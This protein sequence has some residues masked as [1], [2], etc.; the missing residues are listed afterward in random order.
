MDSDL[1][2]YEI[3]MF[4]FLM[5]CELLQAT[6]FGERGATETGMVLVAVA[7][8]LLGT[9]GVEQS[10]QYLRE[11]GWPKPNRDVQLFRPERSRHDEN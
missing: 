6:P 1:A 2:A 4:D 3:S 9:K 8:S 7:Y 5:M 11:D 10:L